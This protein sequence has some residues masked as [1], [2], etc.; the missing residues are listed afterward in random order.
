MSEKFKPIALD[1]TDYWRAVILFGRNVASY[2]FALAKSL[3]DLKPQSGQLLKMSDIAP[4]F[5]H[6]ITEHLKIADKQGTSRSSSFLDACRKFNMGELTEEGLLESTVRYGFV[7]V[8][9]AFHVV[10]NDD[11][12]IRF[13]IDERKGMMVSESLMNS[14]N[15]L[16]LTSMQHYHMRPNPGGG[17][18]RPLGN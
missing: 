5:S 18:W 12:P 4:A 8:I 13:Y 16:V 11:I 17:W 14:Q 2:K 3:L 1:T 10:G 15:L 6:H 9:D 7:N